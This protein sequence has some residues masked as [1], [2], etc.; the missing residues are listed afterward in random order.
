[1]RKARARLEE[2]QSF[3]CLMLG[4][5]HSLVYAPSQGFIMGGALKGYDEYAKSWALKPEPPQQV[6]FVCTPEHGPTVHAPVLVMDRA[7]EGW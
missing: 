1:M 6:L 4:H 7:R 2:R 3:D 5:F